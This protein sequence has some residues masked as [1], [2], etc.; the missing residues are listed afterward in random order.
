M[1]KIV[2]ARERLKVVLEE[3]ATISES[4]EGLDAELEAEQ[5]TKFEDLN[6]EQK[7]LKANIAMWETTAA[8]VEEANAVP[9][10]LSSP[11]GPS[12]G[13]A[14]GQGAL[15]VNAN[16]TEP[17]GF[18]KAGGIEAGAFEPTVR[19]FATPIKR[20]GTL[21]AFT[22]PTGPAEAY[23]FGMWLGAAF[24]GHELASKFCRER[25]ISISAALSEG[26]NSAGG[27]FVLP[28]FVTNRIIDLKEEYGVFRANTNVEP[29]ASDTKT[30]MRRVGGPTAYAV[31]ENTEITASDAE[32]DAVNLVARKWGCLTKMSSELDD[33][34]VVSMADKMVA[35]FA[36]AFAKKE[37]ESGFIGDGTSTYHGVEGV[38]TKMGAGSYF[39]MGAGDRAFS[40]I[41]LIDSETVMSK[42]PQYVLTRGSPKWYVSSVG[43][44]MWMQRLMDAAGGNTIGDLSQGVRYQFLGFPVV[45]TQTLHA[46]TTDAAVDTVIALFG[47]LRMGTTLGDRRSFRVAISKERY[48]EFDQIGIMAT[49]R[50][51]INCHDVGTAST[52]G[53]VCGLRTGAS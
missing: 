49:T 45:I 26:V 25:G 33:D 15:G 28:E 50:F 38:I 31:G 19:A 51:D 21:K 34:S 46:V 48:F 11:S 44:A 37:D 41:T 22:G 42:L 2:Q 3:M 27:F 32:W 24:F 13:M 8:A 17:P 18:R 7:R 14:F 40:D 43:F 53:P 12:T 16:D 6:T 52:A 30:V 1:D 23:A 5:A 36:Y 39:A 4:V 10:R 47:D 20:L 29:M 9:A 35:E